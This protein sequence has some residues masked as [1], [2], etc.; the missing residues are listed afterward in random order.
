MLVVTGVITGNGGQEERL[1][2]AGGHVGGQRRGCMR[3]QVTVGCRP[4]L[5]DFLKSM[6]N[7][8]ALAERAE[9][10]RAVGRMRSVDP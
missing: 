1:H 3:R 6:E 10:V 4:G 5:Q 7:F 9:E 2:A 8:V